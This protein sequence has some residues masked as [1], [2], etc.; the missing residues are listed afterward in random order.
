MSSVLH[1]IPSSHR[2]SSLKDEDYDHEI[3]LVDRTQTTTRSR[4]NFTSD[5]NYRD[6]HQLPE[7]D[8][9]RRHSDDQLRKK[10]TLR[11]E[12]ERRRYSKPKYQNRHLGDDL[13][14]SQVPKDVESPSDDIRTLEIEATPDGGRPKTGESSRST[15][16]AL[17][18]GESTIDILYENQRGC[19]LCGKALF[20]SRAL[21]AADFPPWTNAAQKPSLTNITNAQVPDPTWEWA[22]KGWSVNHSDKVDEDGWEYSFMFSKKN[23]YS[24][25]GPKWYNSFVRRRAWIRK[26]VKKNSGYIVQDANR[27]NSDYFTIQPAMTRS[28]SPSK[29]PSMTDSRHSIG[30]LARR[31]IYDELK[32]EDIR[33]IASLMKAL[34]LSR[35]DREKTEAVENFIKNGGDD[36]FYLK[37]NMHDIMSQFIFQASRRSLLAHLSTLLDEESQRLKDNANDDAQNATEQRRIA[38]LEAALRAADEEVKRLEFWSD[39]KDIAQQGET[40]GAVD[41]SQGWDQKKWSGLDNSGPK[42]V[43]SD[44]ELAAAPPDNSEPEKR[45]I[46]NW[47]GKEKA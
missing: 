36:L 11:E 41:Q 31:D 30:Q 45:G 22:W 1:A 43:I 26:R 34:K 6:S 29:A 24:W 16:K 10:M 25:H 14:D 19:Y 40:K 3:G 18:D 12:I 37:E 47:K 5:S 4:N 44:R 46:D 32:P 9:A 42:D 15:K 39:I 33:D 7:D 13:N 2:P 20:S 35:I 28:R 27:L 21:G 17:V 23:L 38:D 8:S